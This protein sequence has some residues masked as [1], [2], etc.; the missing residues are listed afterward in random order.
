[1]RVLDREAGVAL[2]ARTGGGV[3]EPVAPHRHAGSRVAR[4]ARETLLAVV[5]TAAV[6]VRVVRERELR[7]VVRVL[8]HECPRAAG[9]ARGR[10]AQRLRA[11][12]AI[13]LFALEI[14][15]AGRG[16]FEKAIERTTL[17]ALHVAAVVEAEDAIR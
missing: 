16:A 4:V 9:G 12:A 17:G 5:V 6:V 13:T 2:D 15:D 3:I 14:A 10:H 8:H 7:L 11:A 1:M